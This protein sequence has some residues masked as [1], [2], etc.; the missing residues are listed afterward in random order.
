MLLLLGYFAPDRNTRDGK[1]ASRSAVALHKRPHNETAGAIVE[2]PRRRAG[3]TLKAITVHAS[4]AAMIPLRHGSRVGP[5][6][7]FEDMLRSDM[8]SIDIVQPAIER[9]GNNR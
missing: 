8:K 7:C 6:Y 1:L 5:L 3:A 2:L 9:L 4:P